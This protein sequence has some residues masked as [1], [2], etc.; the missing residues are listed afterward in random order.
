MAS[1]V[2][3][4]ADGTVRVYVGDEEFVRNAIRLRLGPQSLGAAVGYTDERSSGTL[5]AI[6][7]DIS[8]AEGWNAYQGFISSGR[9]PAGDAPG[10]VD[11]SSSDVY[12]SLSQRQLEARIGSAKVSFL[13]REA[14]YQALETTNADGSTRHEIIDRIDGVTVVHRV[15]R[16]PNGS[17]TSSGGSLLLRDVDPD[18]LDNLQLA[19]GAPTTDENGGQNVRL[20]FTDGQ[21]L[22]L[23]DQALEALAWINRPENNPNLDDDVT[24]GQIQELLRDGSHNGAINLYGT[25]FDAGTVERLAT[26]ETPGEILHALRMYGDGSP[27]AVVQ[28]LWDTAANSTAYR[29][30]HEPGADDLADHPAA[31][32]LDVLGSSSGGGC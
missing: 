18:L 11:S 27:N 8:T 30:G 10:V 14:R 5:H 28:L 20:D 21:L 1:G 26:A 22:A 31:G 7:L 23:Q 6:D 3:R 29:I 17:V 19:H 16:A 25:P 32:D 2:T 9:L 15:D 4:I 12:R 13:D 24:P